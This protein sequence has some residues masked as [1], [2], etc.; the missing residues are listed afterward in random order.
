M[1]KNLKITLV[2]STIGSK[3]AHR[4][5]VQTLGLRK[6]GQSVVREDTPGNRGLVN[7]V[8]HLVTVEE[9]D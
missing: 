8:R 4:A 7:A 6:I 1:A 2:R 9:V 3:P 5:T